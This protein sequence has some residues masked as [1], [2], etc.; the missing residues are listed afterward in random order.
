[1]G[2]VAGGV[3]GEAN[4]RAW[5]FPAPAAKAMTRLKDLP[6]NGREVIRLEMIA[7]RVS[8]PETENVHVRSYF[9]ETL[10]INPEIITDK[11]G[12]AEISVP[13]AD[14]IT[15]W[16]M[17]MMASTQRGTLG[18]ATSSLKVF[19]DFFVDLDLPVTLTQGDQVS[20]PVAIY[21]Y[22][23]GKGDVR[24]Q[25]KED[26][27]FSL[28]ED[29]GKKSVD[30]DRATRRRIAIYA[31]SEADREVQADAFCAHCKGARSA[32]TSWCGRSKWFPTAASRAWFST[33]GWRSAVSHEVKFPAN[34]I[35]EPARSLCGSTPDR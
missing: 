7:P 35:A 27:W 3:A 18:T 31:A 6:I 15:T 10:Y 11:N 29:P 28:V 5:A 34:S 22:S 16:R 23:D 26:D 14:N 13:L 19:Q 32:L 24:L 12:N 4:G 21:N 1:M 17:A 9:P 8:E 20:I 30:V 2:G 33:G 25:L